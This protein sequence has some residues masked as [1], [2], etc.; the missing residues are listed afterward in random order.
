MHRCTFPF[1]HGQMLAHMHAQMHAHMRSCMH[2][3]TYIFTPDC[4][5]PFAV[6]NASGSEHG[7]NRKG[8]LVH[9]LNV[10]QL[11][12][13]AAHFSAPVC[14]TWTFMNRTFSSLSLLLFALRPHQTF[15]ISVCNHEESHGLKVLGVYQAT[16]FAITKHAPGTPQA[17]KAQDPSGTL[18]INPSGMQTVWCRD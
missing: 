7:A 4:L 2:A 9:L 12:D 10:L 13:G 11:K 18:R 17:A 15:P 3:C 5:H 6:I 1:G 16:C 14:S 8:F